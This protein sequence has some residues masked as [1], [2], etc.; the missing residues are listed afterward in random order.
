METS[1]GVAFLVGLSEA[2]PPFG[3][4]CHGLDFSA[5]LVALEHFSA[6]SRETFFLDRQQQTGSMRER[7]TES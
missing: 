2:A 7:K 6:N 4:Q 3:C 1:A 5:T